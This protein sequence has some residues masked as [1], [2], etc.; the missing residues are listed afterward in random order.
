MLRIHD[1]DFSVWKKS[2]FFNCSYAVPLCFGSGLHRKCYRYTKIMANNIG[3][4]DNLR[5]TLEFR[6][7]KCVEA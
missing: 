6:N 3:G 1:P 4:Q 2:D 5:V 7:Q